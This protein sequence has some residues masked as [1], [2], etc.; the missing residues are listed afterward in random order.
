[1]CGC[2]D[3][4]GCDDS[5]KQRESSEGYVTADQAELAVEMLLR[6]IEHVHDSETLRDGLLDTPK[7]VVDEIRERCI[8]G[9]LSE[10]EDCDLYFDDW[11]SPPSSVHSMAVSNPIRFVSTCERT[12]VTISGTAHVGHIPNGFSHTLDFEKV[13]RLVS[14]V[15]KRLQTRKGIVEGIMSSTTMLNMA[16]IVQF[17]QGFPVGCMESGYSGAFARHSNIR[18]EFQNHVLGGKS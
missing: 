17:D 12:L 5:V 7:R 6:H 2:D 18:R 3:N 14:I 11:E 9:Y 8:S 10:A 15:T 4:S 13:A 1:M 16:C